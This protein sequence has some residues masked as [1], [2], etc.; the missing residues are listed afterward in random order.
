VDGSRNP[1]G[2]G[3]VVS[4]RAHAGYRPDF[5]AL[6]SGQV[7]A[8]RAKLGLS[9]AEF[10]EHLGEILGWM[11]SAAAVKKW[12]QG[13]IPPGD[14]LLSC[15]MVTQNTSGDMLAFPRTAT[16]QQAAAL[17]SDISPALDRESPAPLLWAV[18]HSFPADALCGPWVTCYQFRH[19]GAQQHHADIAHI[20]AGSDRHIRATN[21]PPSPRTEGRTSPFRNEIEAQLTNRHLVGHW[22]NTSDARYFGSIHLAVLPG[23]TVMEG[24]YTG[25]ASDILVSTGPWKWVRLAPESLSGDVLSKISLRDPSVLY[26]LVMNYSQ[27]DVPLTLADIGEET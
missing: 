7:S 2:A 24:Y 4:I 5:K 25:F 11:P 22:K 10:A 3:E 1:A 17:L 26:E 16:V 9:H 6:A 12:E 18:P 13:S 27:Y 19:G 15:A 23:E 8:A 20:T 21:H 14:V